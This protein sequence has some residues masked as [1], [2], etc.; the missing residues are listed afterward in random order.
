MPPQVYIIIVE[1]IDYNKGVVNML[2]AK[3]D[4][5]IEMCK[6]VKIKIMGI[7]GNMQFDVEFDNESFEIKV[8]PFKI[9]PSDFMKLSRRFNLI[10]ER[11]LRIIESLISKRKVVFEIKI[12]KDYNFDWM[13]LKKNS[14]VLSRNSDIL[15]RELD[16]FCNY[17]KVRLVSILEEAN[18]DLKGVI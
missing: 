10:E 6:S 16:I 13:P 11:D 3:S 7:L 1:Y 4:K 15:E 12:D 14:T 18:N 9:M 8:P 17:L 5:V 2:L